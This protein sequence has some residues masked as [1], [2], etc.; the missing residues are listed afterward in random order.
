[1]KGVGEASGHR[2]FDIYIPNST[3]RI[4]EQIRGCCAQDCLPVTCTKPPLARELPFYFSLAHGDGQ[5]G[6]EAARSSACA[7][8][9]LQPSLQPIGWCTAGDL[10]RVP[11][12]NCQV[13]PP[14]VSLRAGVRVCRFL[15]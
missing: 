5:Q 8:Q 3:V 7:L 6:A 11:G 14:R 15:G 2:E 9:P 13:S 1:M 12:I 4:G 10:P